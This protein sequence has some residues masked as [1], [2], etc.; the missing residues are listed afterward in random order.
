LGRDR[1]G[2][3]VALDVLRDGTRVKLDLSVTERPDERR[4]A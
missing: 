1:I 2:R 4:S 3:R